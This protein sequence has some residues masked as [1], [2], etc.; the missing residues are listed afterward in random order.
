MHVLDPWEYL[1]TVLCITK[2]HPVNRVDELAPVH[3]ARAPVNR[4]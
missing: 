4:E 2:D 1:H 3:D